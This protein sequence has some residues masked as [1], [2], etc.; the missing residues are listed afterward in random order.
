MGT[1]NSTRI[2]EGRKCLILLAIKV[3][4]C[5]VVGTGVEGALC[6]PESELYC[7]E[8]KSSARIINGMGK[9]GDF[10]G[11]II[12]AVIRYPRKLHRSRNQSGLYFAIDHVQVL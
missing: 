5:T 1:Y 2:D 8:G 3:T 6:G 10:S 9:K 7:W 4:A 11:Y 12:A